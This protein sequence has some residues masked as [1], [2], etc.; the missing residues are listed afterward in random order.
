MICEGFVR[1]VI[2]FDRCKYFLGDI[3]KRDTDADV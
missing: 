2:Y 1:A 3:L